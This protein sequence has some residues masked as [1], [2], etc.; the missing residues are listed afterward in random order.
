MILRPAAD[1]PV[2]HRDGLL[3]AI[4]GLATSMAADR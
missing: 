1:M 2:E 3:R 4:A